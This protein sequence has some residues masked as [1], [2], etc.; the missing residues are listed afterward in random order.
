MTGF[1]GSPRVARASLLALDAST[2]A[3]L[4]RV[5]LQYN[6]DQLT[7]SLQLDADP[8]RAGLPPAETYRLEL[9]L[10]ATDALEK[11]GPADAVAVQLAA[12][13]ALVHPTSDALASARQL[14]ARGTL[15]LLA[16]DPPRLLLVFGGRSVPVRISEYSVVEE[17][18][19]PDLQPIRARVTLGLRVQTDT[20]Q[21]FSYRRT[22]E[23][24]AGRAGR[25]GNQ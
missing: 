8:Q 19:G 9:E 6:P 13:E 15:E 2:G 1:P 4:Q 24:L 11:G 18:F 25:G 7:R 3:P 20:D 12:L 14:A 22:R 17:A 16:P 10:D 5:T 23:Q 21:F